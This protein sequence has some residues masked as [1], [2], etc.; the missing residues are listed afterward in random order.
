ME[1]EV[2]KIEIMDFKSIKLEKLKVSPTSDDVEAAV[3][4]IGGQNPSLKRKR[5]IK[6][7]ILLLL[8]LWVELMA[9]NLVG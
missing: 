6:K 7:A 9:R 5:I 1:L 4:L 3:G 2:F 8:I